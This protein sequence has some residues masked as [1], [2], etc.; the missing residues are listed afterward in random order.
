MK[1][2]IISDTHI[3]SRFYRSGQLLEFLKSIEYD[4]IILAGDIIDF[5]RIPVF[6]E[7][8][9]E[10]LSSVDRSK[11]VVYV[12]GNHDESLVGLVGKKIM[13]IRFVNKYEF[14]E[15]GRRFRVEHGDSY[16]EGWLHKKL[17]VKFISMMQSLLEIIFDFD[18][19][20]WW[21]KRYIQKHKLRTIINILKYNDDVDVFVMGHTHNPEAL[22]WIDADQQIK[23][24]INS[25]DW[26]THQTYVE[27]N[28][29][30]ARLRK[31]E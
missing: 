3:G 18:L 23:T 9:I 29:G 4:Q 1:R 25:G 5:I 30:V 11:D 7:R 15:G 26:I 6:T 8:C 27:I 24:Y 14:D 19:T 22:I 20:T 10:I 12:V 13:G 21:T 17:F 2:V 28:D 16:D 31:Y